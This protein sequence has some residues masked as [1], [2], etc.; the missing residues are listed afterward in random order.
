MN[1]PT[2]EKSPSGWLQATED[3]ENLFMGGTMISRSEVV[4]TAKAAQ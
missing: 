3:V 1:S 2:W 4:D